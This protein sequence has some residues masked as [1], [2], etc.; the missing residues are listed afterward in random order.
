MIKNRVSTFWTLFAGLALFLGLCQGASARVMDPEP[1]ER[2][3][4][5]EPIEDINVDFDQADPIGQLL[6]SLTAKPNA[7]NEEVV[8]VLMNA[9]TQS[10]RRQSSAENTEVADARARLL[11]EIGK[12]QDPR[13]FA[14]LTA[15]LS[16]FSNIW[17]GP[18]YRPVAATAAQVLDRYDSEAALPV[19][20]NLVQTSKNQ[21]LRREVIDILAGRQ[22]EGAKAA[23]RD[24]L[25]AGSA[26]DKT[27][28]VEEWYLQMASSQTKA[29]QTRTLISLLHSE[30]DPS[31]L[32]AIVDFLSHQ[33][34]NAEAK[35]ALLGVIRVRIPSHP[36][37][38]LRAEGAEGLAFLDAVEAIPDLERL[39]ND[40][41]DAVHLAALKALQ[42]L[43]G[44]QDPFKKEPDPKY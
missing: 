21:A 35:D 5:V 40:P 20:L 37:Y 12:R 11:E 31:L 34:R 7:T 32:K 2:K 38:G 17:G 39:A 22:D 23:V 4:A 14:F 18:I 29:D 33:Y 19:F 3:S 25:T 8:T 43:A 9:V 26:R 28:V 42:D 41:D 6:A 27:T 10:R 30:T 16:D 1:R 36:L 15:Q 13:V 44:A 24:I